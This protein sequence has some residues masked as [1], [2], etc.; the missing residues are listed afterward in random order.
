MISLLFWPAIGAVATTD[1]LGRTFVHIY[2][3]LGRRIETRVEPPVI[4]CPD[5]PEGECFFMG[6]VRRIAYEYEP[7]GLLARVAAYARD[8]Q[9]QEFVAAENLFEYDDR[10]H[11]IADWQAH[12]DFVGEATP[13][14]DYAWEFSPLPTVDPP[15]SGYNFDRLVNLTYPERP[16]D[17]TRRTVTLNYG[18]NLGDLDPGHTAAAKGRTPTAYSL[19]ESRRVQGDSGLSRVPRSMTTL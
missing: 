9:D 4:A 18:N 15:V 13:V 3:A 17:A 19:R 12:Y 10:R 6:G 1:A 7:D 8:E 5:P 16:Q 11:L 2:D 14:V